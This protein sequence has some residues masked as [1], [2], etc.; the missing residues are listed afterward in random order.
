MLFY[1]NK[2]LKLIDICTMAAIYLD[3][4]LTS[5]LCSIFLFGQNRS[6]FGCHHSYSVFLRAVRREDVR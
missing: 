4:N 3:S 5:N 2:I 6:V 1:D